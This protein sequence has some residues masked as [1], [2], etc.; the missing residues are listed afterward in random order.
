MGQPL[1]Q[2]WIQASIQTYEVGSPF[3]AL[4]EGILMAALDSRYTQ[5]GFNLVSVEVCLEGTRCSTVHRLL[6]F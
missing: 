2:V 3:K 4:I 1:D 6:V 5:V